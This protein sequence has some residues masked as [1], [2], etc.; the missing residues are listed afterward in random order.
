MPKFA[1]N[2]TW[3]FNEIDFTERFS[4]AASFGFR[5]AEC[6]F[7]YQWDAELLSQECSAA[8]LQMIMFNMPPGELDEGEYG[9][10]ALPG[11]E[12]DFRQSVDLAL[13]YATTLNCP[14]LHM[15]AGIV[16]EGDSHDEYLETYI[17]NLAWAAGV[18]APLDITVLV[19]PINTFERPG[20]LISTT[21]QA[22]EAIRQCNMENV[23]MQFD[24]HN[25]QLMEGNLTALLTGNLRYIR[26]MQIAGVPNRTPPDQ[27]EL[28]Y[29]YLFDLVDS[30][31]YQGWLGC[32]FRPGDNTVAGLSLLKQ[33]GLG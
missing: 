6:Q 27:G 5:A 20:Y 3:L 11:R 13:K 32:E 4:A 8:E 2:L 17:K 19:E 10:A 24:F 14:M 23:A 29:P 21:G 1:A 33:Y 28:N 7:P 31:G 25:A 12:S 30:S 18:C 26:H 16:P 15:L 22:R 9:L